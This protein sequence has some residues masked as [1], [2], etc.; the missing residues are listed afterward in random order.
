MCACLMLRVVLFLLLN[1]TGH[2]SSGA[3]IL[4]GVGLFYWL[5]PGVANV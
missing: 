3:T 1:R 4:L 2:A 5:G